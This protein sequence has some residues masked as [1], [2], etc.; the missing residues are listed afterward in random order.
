MSVAVGNVGIY[1]TKAQIPLSYP[2]WG[3]PPVDNGCLCRSRDDL[4]QVGKHFYLS[5]GFPPG[6]DQRIWGIAVAWWGGPKT[7]DPGESPRSDSIIRFLW[8]TDASR[9]WGFKDGMGRGSTPLCGPELFWGCLL[10][11]PRRKSPRFSSGPWSG[12]RFLRVHCLLYA[13]P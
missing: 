6:L 3:S 7:L 1:A 10:F 8:T 5:L 11:F 12:G 2:A 13:P 4:D 9:P